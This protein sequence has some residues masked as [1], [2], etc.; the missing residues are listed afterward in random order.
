[1]Y[2]YMYNFFLHDSFCPEQIMLQ[3]LS[4]SNC[5]KKETTSTKFKNDS[6]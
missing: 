1:M 6:L 2:I 5:V 3:F 4:Y